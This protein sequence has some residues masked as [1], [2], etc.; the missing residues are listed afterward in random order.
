MSGKADIGIRIMKNNPRIWGDVYNVAQDIVDGCVQMPTGRNATYDMQD[1]ADG[2]M[3]AAVMNTSVGGVANGIKDIDKARNAILGRPIPS[4]Q[5]FNNIMSKTNPKDAI[6][7]FS[8][9]VF[10]LL[11]M[12]AKINH[13]PKDGLDIAIDMHKICRYDKNPGTELIRSKSKNGTSTFEC[14]ITAQ[15]V[16]EDLRLI[17]GCLP[18]PTG[19]TIP[20]MVRDL[21][22]MCRDVGARINTLL[23]DREFFSTGALEA[24]GELNVHYLMPC[25]NTPGVKKALN[26]FAAGKR[27]AVSENYLTGSKRRVAYTMIITERKKKK[28]KSGEEETPA[29]EERFIGFATNV[30][31]VDITKYAS[32]WGIETGYSM[33]EKMRAQTRSRNTGARLLC[34]LYSLMVFNGWVM[35]NTLEKY[36]LTARLRGGKKITQT[37]LK[38]ML[39]FAA[40]GK[41]DT[42]PLPE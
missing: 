41:I 7:S 13:L 14:Y 24:L 29:P 25:T 9:M 11:S 30:P 12:L 32:R 22:N 37:A 4:D 3:H 31:N 17:L 2:M 20:D 5:W 38:L 27:Q 18:V 1:F 23:L 21:V 33:I 40:N 34:F 10:R 15:C 19:A 36:R 8:V 6:S 35:V 28:G 39:L 42:G 26:E 16:N